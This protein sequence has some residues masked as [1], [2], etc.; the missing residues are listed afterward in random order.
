MPAISWRLTELVG[1]EEPAG[2][3]GKY[4]VVGTERGA[5]EERL[6]LFVQHLVDSVKHGIDHGNRRGAKLVVVISPD[7]K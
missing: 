5:A 7:V 1:E 2:V 6:R 3:R 4:D